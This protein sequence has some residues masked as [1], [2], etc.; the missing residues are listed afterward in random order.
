MLKN[1]KSMNENYNI[2]RPIWGSREKRTLPWGPLPN[3]WL[4]PECMG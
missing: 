2:N 3:E 4:E 1:E